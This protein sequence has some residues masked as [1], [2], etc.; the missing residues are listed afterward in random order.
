MVYVIFNHFMSNC[1]E[2]RCWGRYKTVGAQPP[3][4]L[5]PRL[6][7]KQNHPGWLMLK[8]DWFGWCIK[9]CNKKNLEIED[10]QKNSPLELNYH[11]HSNNSLWISMES[12]LHK[13]LPSL[14]NGTE[15]STSG[16]RI[17]KYITQLQFHFAELS[18]KNSKR[19]FICGRKNCKK[20][21]H[22]GAGRGI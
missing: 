3:T 5:R 20:S 22:K 9:N 7:V 4:Q 2:R 10:H 14:V 11:N 17:N 19:L 15:I 12:W 8:I 6:L 1:G 13:V 16:F 18:F 21:T